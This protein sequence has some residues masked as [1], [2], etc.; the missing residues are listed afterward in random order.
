[1]PDFEMKD[2]EGNTQQLSASLGEKLTVVFFWPGEG[3]IAQREAPQHLAD[4]QIDVADVFADRG[5]KIV[6]I[7]YKQPLEDVKQAVAAANVSF[8]ILLDE[9]G[10][11]FAQLGT[12]GLPRTYLIDAERR[13][14]WFDLYFSFD[15]MR[16]LKQAI[17][18]VLADDAAEVP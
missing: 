11:A 1:M 8:P 15:T 16:G 4:L 5:V 10:D 13:I 6:G 7:N 14:L 18:F 12:E 3:R 17:A 9:S 2:L